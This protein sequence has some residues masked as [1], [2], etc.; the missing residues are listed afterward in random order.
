[1]AL[2]VKYRSLFSYIMKRKVTKTSLRNKA[3]RLWS[4]KTKIGISACQYCGA[5]SKYLQSHHLISRSILK[6]RWNLS[7]C[8]VLCP[9]CHNFG[10]H[11]IHT[12]PWIIDRYIQINYPIMFK[13][14]DTNRWD[15]DAVEFS[16]D[17]YR[18]IVEE[19]E[20]TSTTATTA[21]TVST[22]S[23]PD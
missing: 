1:M 14:F 23:T 11:S 8:I 12:S 13:W 18:A 4:S 15:L 7:N 9:S 20:A 19:L 6:Y 2:I 3:D 21:T 5:E 16:I 17:D 22:V 10:K